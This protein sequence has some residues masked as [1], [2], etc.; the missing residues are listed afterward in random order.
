VSDL[1]D[2][3]LEVVSDPAE[4]AGMRPSWNAAAAADPTPNVYLTWEWVH[5]WW[6]HFGEGNELHVVVVRDDD[7]IVAIAP[8]QRSRL[9]VGPGPLSTAVLQRISPDAGDYGGIVLV[10]R[11]A[12]AVEVIVDHLEAALR[13]RS[14]AAVVLS[15]L[16]SDDPFLALLRAELVRRTATL[17]A[18]EA[19]LGG[20]CLFTDLRSDF[21]MT[22]QT[23]KH[24]IRQRTRRIGEQHGEVVFA[25]HSDG[26]VGTDGSD[27]S[28]GSLDEGLDRL[29]HV[30]ARRWEGRESEMQGLLAEPE[31]EAFMVDAIRALDGAG[32][33][34]LLTLTADGR[35]VAAEL[36]FE[37]QRRMFMFK[38]AFDPDFGA[39]SPGQLLHHRV[40]EDGLEAGLDVVDW[41]RGDQL[42]KRRWANGERHQVTVTMTR[43]GLGGRLDAQ[44]LRATRAL[45]RRLRG[46]GEG[47]SESAESDSESDS[48]DD[49]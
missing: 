47:S 29:L 13:D 46:S 1:G 15:R 11:E 41:G 17:G 28:D 12:E 40:I 3:R 6:T 7:G 33:V 42:Y 45:E 8:L 18:A 27:G 35:P 37:F 49:S 39:F 20:S 43:S 9:G 24:K 32:R 26:A 31:R 2:L 48:G 44:R 4:L 30:H 21:N 34:R 23:K 16:V 25:Y 38:G 36:D 14:V 5:T 22:K 19:A 10:R